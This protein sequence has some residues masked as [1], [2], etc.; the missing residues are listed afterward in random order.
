MKRKILFVIPSL[1]AGGAERV[2]SYLIKKLDKSKFEC[3][4]LVLG[5]KENAVYQ[6]DDSDVI[7]LN[8]PRLLK[9]IPSIIRAILKVKPD[10]V[11]SSIGHVNILMGTLSLF[12]R[13][14]KFI[15]REASVIT[16]MKQFS[17]KKKQLAPKAIKFLYSRFSKIVCQ[18]TDMKNDFIKNYKLA[19][20][21]LEVI[22]NPITR[23]NENIKPV[24]FE[25]NEV[26]VKF[27]TIGRLS[28]EKGHER[29]L[30]GLSKV[31]DYTYNYLVIGSG[32]LEENIKNQAKELGIEKNIKFIPFTNQ[33]LNYLSGSDCF[34]Q[35]S[36]VEGFPNALLESCSVGTP[37][38]A[39]NCPGGTKEIIS[40]GV[41]GYLINN[42][43]DFENK[44][45]NIK[46]MLSS[47]NRDKV[48]KS[49][50]LKFSSEKILTKYMNLFLSA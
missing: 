11:F 36:Y 12:F 28:K 30:K 21:K 20:N 18:S 23:S 3:K 14:I 50:Q 37:A 40:D 29:I 9:S 15:A 39:F 1:K 16:A 2:I 42:D 35:G 33:V 13:K 41:N 49:I 6:I 26:D 48:Q 25:E 43:R 34:I 32:E 4:L 22:N 27:I 38:L 7:Y 17:N 31:K 47:I 46:E 44:L 10:I 19:S 5:F 8:K 24:L 45:L